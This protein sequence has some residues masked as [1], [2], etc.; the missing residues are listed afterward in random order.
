MYVRDV[1]P[2]NALIPMLVTIPRKVTDVSEVVLWNTD[3]S[4]TVTPDGMMTDRKA[5]D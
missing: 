3:V 4:I 5:V 2:W 1:V